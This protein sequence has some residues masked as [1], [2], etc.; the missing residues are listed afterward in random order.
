MCQKETPREL[1]TIH[2]PLCVCVGTVGGPWPHLAG[3]PKR[4][5]SPHR[6]IIP[7]L[8]PGGTLTAPSSG[9]CLH[10]D[11]SLLY[12]ARQWSLLE[13]RSVQNIGVKTLEK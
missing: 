11:I 8:I 5:D 13:M 7:Q 9:R 10:Y 12:T 2:E 6:R 3:E 1:G 4:R